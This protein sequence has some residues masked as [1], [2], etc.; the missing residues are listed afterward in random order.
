MIL[1]PEDGRAFR[2]LVAADPL[3]DAGPVVEPVTADVNPRV[4]PVYSS[5][6]IQILSVS[7]IASALLVLGRIVVPDDVRWACAGE[8]DELGRRETDQVRG[9]TGAHPDERMAEQGSLDEHLL[10]LGSGNGA[11]APGANPVAR[12]TSCG[13][14]TRA[15][16]V[17]AALATFSRS[18]CR[19]PGTSART[20]PLSLTRTS[21]FTIWSRSQPTA[22]AASAA[23]RVLSANASMRASAPASRRK[24]ETRST[25]SGQA[26]TTSE[27]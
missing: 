21:D 20:G 12:S 13:D 8:S 3:E 1:Q 26:A 9:R 17:P 10:Y 5:P 4:R 18:P 6:F 19:S 16:S 15:D 7:C 24:E 2:G 25:G 27:M 22:A 23:V 14:A 11:T